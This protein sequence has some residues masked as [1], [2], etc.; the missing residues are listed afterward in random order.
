MKWDKKHL[1]PKPT[2]KPGQDE[3]S[4]LFLLEHAENVGLTIWSSFQKVFLDIVSLLIEDTNRYPNRDKN[5][6]EFSL[7]S[8]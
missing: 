7:T 5:K 3:K 6:P 4:Q 1:N 8:N 2:S